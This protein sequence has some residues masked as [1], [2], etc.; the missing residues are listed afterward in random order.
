MQHGEDP[1]DVTEER[2]KA[3]LVESPLMQ[4]CHPE[5]VAIALGSFH[6]QYRLDGGL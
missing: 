1:S 2:Y 4:D 6:Q 3:F 5:N